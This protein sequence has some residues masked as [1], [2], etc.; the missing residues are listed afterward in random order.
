MKPMR[1]LINDK[2]THRKLLQ[3]L[4]ASLAAIV[5]VIYLHSLAPLT[6]DRQLRAAALVESEEYVEITADGKAVAWCGG[7]GADGLPRRMSLKAD[8]TV[9]SRTYANGLWVNKYPFMPSCRGLLIIACGD[10]CDDDRTAA[11]DNDA[12]AVIAKAVRLTAERVRL[13]DEKTEEADYYMRVHNVNDDGY[14]VVAEYSARLKTERDEA[15][16]LLTVLKSLQEKRE[17]GFRQVRRYTL[18]YNDTSG[19]VRRKACRRLTPGGDKRFTLL[20]TADCRLPDG[21]AAVYLHQWL[22]P[23]PDAGDSVR[24]TSIPG[25]RAYGFSPS[26]AAAATFGGTAGSGLRHDLPPILAPDGCAVYTPAGFL[27]GIS[28]GGRVYGPSY[29]GY[30]LKHLLE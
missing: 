6:A 14:N 29:F 20:Q 8:S 9:V 26:A 12:R 30:A 11:A 5:F 25:C 1:K 19:T 7:I 28:S 22:T 4:P 10:G 24:A 18:L 21:A 3:S 2:T 17:I 16:R 23:R 15:A 13:M 27:I